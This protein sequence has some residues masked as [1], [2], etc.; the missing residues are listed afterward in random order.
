MIVPEHAK[1]IPVDG[2]EDTP[3]LPNAIEVQF[4]PAT[5]KVALS[6]TLK[7]NR[8]AG[9]NRAAQFVDKSSS[10]LSVELVFDTTWIDQDV[11]R[12]HRER[13]AGEGRSAEDVA[14]GSDVRKLTSRIAD[15]FIKPVE[16]GDQLLAPKRCLFQWGAFEFLGLVQSFDE[17]L[18]F[19]SPEGR[20][21]R[22]TVALRL[23]ES[24]YQFRSRELELAQRD[25]PAFA[26]AGA[27]ANTPAGAAS[28]PDVLPASGGSASE[29]RNWRQTA[30]FNGV[31]SPRMPS[32]AAL[33]VPNLSAGVAIGSGSGAPPP[34]FRF[35]AS[36]SVG[37]GIQGAFGDPARPQSL[38]ATL[39][40]PTPRADTKGRINGTGVG[41]D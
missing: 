28:R 35:G 22:A 6:N 5:L 17:T 27:D 1:L 40:V 7:E 19:F 18:D 31:E 30:L 38:S 29:Q 25:T 16:Q 4:N 36:A 9:N 24:R 34:A 3:D 20:P 10:T 23:S 33:A 32:V 12:V 21:L 39:T 11:A 13:A 41:F 26:A 15:T 2:T 14:A 8:N 37:T